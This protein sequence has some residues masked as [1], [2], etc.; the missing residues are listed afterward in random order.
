LRAPARPRWTE[1]DEQPSP[2]RLAAIQRQTELGAVLR[3][4][5]LSGAVKG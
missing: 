4:S 2:S 5:G 3:G 1:L